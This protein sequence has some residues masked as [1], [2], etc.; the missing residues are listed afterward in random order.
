MAPIPRYNSSKNE[1]PFGMLMPGRSYS[2]TAYK[3]GFNGKEKDDEVSGTGNQYDYGFRIY[4]PRIAKF[5]SVDPLTKSYPLLTPYQFAENCPIQFI[6][7]DGLE[8]GWNL[9]SIGATLTMQTG[10]I[11]NVYRKPVVITSKPAPK[12]TVPEQSFVQGGIQGTEEFKIYKENVK[13]ACEIS[14]YAP[15]TGDIHDGKDAISDF[16]AGNYKSAAFSAFFLVPGTDMLKLS[17][18]IPHSWS[19]FGV[20]TYEEFREFTKKLSVEDRIAKFKEVA[21]DIAKNNGWEKNNRLSGLNN[22]DVFEIKNAKGE[23]EGY[24]SLDKKTGSFEILDTKGRHQGESNF[25]G[26]KIDDADKSGKHDIKLK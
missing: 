18:F 25:D 22:R 14:Q 11:G 13:V 21:A 3:Y 6:D 24:R 5:L 23:I 19:K 4:N 8:S 10:D 20:N 9:S 7:I 15:V 17:K 12:L 1:H 16:L 26:I 2:S